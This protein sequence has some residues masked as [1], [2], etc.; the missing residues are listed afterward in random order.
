MALFLIGSCFAL[1]VVTDYMC[2]PIAD[3]ICSGRDGLDAML[4]VGWEALCD[5]SLPALLAKYQVFFAVYAVLLAAYWVYTTFIFMWMCQDSMQ[6]PNKYGESPKY[7]HGHS[8][9]AS[10]QT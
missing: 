2:V 7:V 6:Q 3:A 10:A 1:V 8:A 4:I 9:P 5:A